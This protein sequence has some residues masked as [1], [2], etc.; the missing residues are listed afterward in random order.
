VHT[1][2]VLVLPSCAVLNFHKVKSD[3]LCI[4]ISVRLLIMLYNNNSVLTHGF[5]YGIFTEN[6]YYY[7]YGLLVRVYYVCV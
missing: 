7:S 4:S 6:Q 2:S 3:W 1:V 5:P